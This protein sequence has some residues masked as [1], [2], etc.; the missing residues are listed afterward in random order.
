[1]VYHIV[2][3]FS[4]QVFSSRQVPHQPRVK[5]ARPTAHRDSS[6]RR[7]THAGINTPS[8]TDRCQAG[9]V[10]QMG[11]Y[12]AAPDSLCASQSRQFF[13]QKCERES[14][15]T[16]SFNALVRETSRQRN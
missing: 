8:L 11:K 16:E 7:K 1:M 13:H 6:R 5:V 3:L 4:A 15:E 9:T 14:M 2:K 10:A 12:N